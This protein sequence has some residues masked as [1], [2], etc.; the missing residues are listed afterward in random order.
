MPV[1]AVDPGLPL[2]HSESA[3][4]ICKIYNLQE[5]LQGLAEAFHKG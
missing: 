1:S 2:T 5:H 4:H 3:S